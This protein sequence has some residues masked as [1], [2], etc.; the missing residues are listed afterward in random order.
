MVIFYLSGNVDDLH[1]SMQYDLQSICYWMN[2]KRLSHNTNMTKF[3]LLGS[4][5]K[6]GKVPNFGLSLNGAQIEDV[7]IF[8]Y[9]GMTLDSKLMFNGHISPKLLTKRVAS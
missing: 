2:E 1:L 4:K 5:A 8:K 7:E 3:M 9:L 6:L